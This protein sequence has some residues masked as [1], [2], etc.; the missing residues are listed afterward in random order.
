MQCELGGMIENS[1][2]LEVHM[3]RRGHNIDP[4]MDILHK[5]TVQVQKQRDN[6][7]AVGQK[8]HFLFLKMLFKQEK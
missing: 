5:T 2:K 7:Q 1:P 8:P 6:L 3:R 4:C